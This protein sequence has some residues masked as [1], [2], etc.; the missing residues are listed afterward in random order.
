MS[1]NQSTRQQF[2]IDFLKTTTLVPQV[3]KGIGQGINNKELGQNVLGQLAN[4][5]GKNG[6]N[7][8]AYA[9]DVDEKLK[10]I[11]EDHYI[12]GKYGVGLDE[13]NMSEIA[14]LLKPLLAEYG[15]DFYDIKFVKAEDIA[16]GMSIN[17]KE[18]VVYINTYGDGFGHS[19]QMLEQ[20]GHEGMHG[21][22]ADKNVDE[23][24]ASMLTKIPSKGWSSSIGATAITINAQG[25]IEASTNQYYKDRVNGDLRDN[26]LIGGISGAFVGM[27]LTMYKSHKMALQGHKFTA[28][29]ANSMLL[30]NMFSGATKGAM[31]GTWNPV[32]IGWACY[33][34]Y[35]EVTGKDLVSGEI[36]SFAEDMSVFLLG[37]HNE[38][39]IN[40]VTASCNAYLRYKTAAMYDNYHTK[41]VAE[42]IINAERIKSGLKA[43]NY[44]RAASYL[45]KKELSKGQVFSWKNGDKT[46][47]TLFQVEG[48]VDGK[49][50][51]FEYIINKDGKVTH[52][53]FKPGKTIT[54]KPN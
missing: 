1:L 34:T 49:K 43:D 52:Q 19:S 33:D 15:K 12:N 24:A 10:N 23:K 20:L 53:L 18:G 4:N 17:D 41:K 37:T 51:I 6:F 14:G 3:A 22:Y 47:V 38:K 42:K 21:T 31:I 46:T 16:S 35:V 27:G 13:Y 36:R 5:L 26:P 39:F 7:I 32:M 30:S 29:E 2:V 50:G 54:G 45:T 28:G 9:Y 40:F 25:M 48:M 44:H 11:I 8:V